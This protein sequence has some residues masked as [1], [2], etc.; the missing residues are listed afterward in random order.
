VP[1]LIEAT[2]TQVQR[3][4]NEDFYISFEGAQSGLVGV[5]FLKPHS[6]RYVRFKTLVVDDHNAYQPISERELTEEELAHFTALV[7]ATAYS[8]N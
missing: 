5:V 7:A 4:G 3:L 1:T 6:G 8:L 2:P